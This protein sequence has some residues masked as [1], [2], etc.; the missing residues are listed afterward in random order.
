[1]EDS[2][3]VGAESRERAVKVRR[4]LCYGVV[5]ENGREGREAAD[6]FGRNGEDK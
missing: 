5:D 3:V 6:I 2:W 4:V 1:M